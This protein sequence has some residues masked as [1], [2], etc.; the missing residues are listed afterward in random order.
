MITRLHERRISAI[1][2]YFGRTIGAVRGDDRQS[3]RHGF[4]QHHP[5]ALPCR[6]QCE[7]SRATH[8]PVRVMLETWQC[9]LVR[10]VMLPNYT[11]NAASVR[12][13]SKN[14]QSSGPAVPDGSEGTNKHWKIFL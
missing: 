5:K 1:A 8:K 6:G 13:F 9:N 4:H 14:H 11:F 3:Q 7:N 12:A 2:E 10:H